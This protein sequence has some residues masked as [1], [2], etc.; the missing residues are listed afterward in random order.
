MVQLEIPGCEYL[1]F[2]EPRAEERCGLSQPMEGG[3]PPRPRRPEG[4]GL[5]EFSKG[6]R[7]PALRMEC[8][9]G[10]GQASF[11]E[12]LTLVA[13]GRVLSLGK[14]MGSS[15]GSDRGRWEGGL[16]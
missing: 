16:V 10:D 5:V 7:S 14:P 8:G 11:W 6:A 12:N 3:C 13:T 4:G 1:V 15:S 2:G 9:S